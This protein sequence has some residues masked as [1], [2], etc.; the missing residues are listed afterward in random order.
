MYEYT[1]HL[2]IGS[3]KVVA[4]TASAIEDL[5]ASAFLTKLWRICGAEVR[6]TQKK[7]IIFVS[8]HIRL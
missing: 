5:A 2:C 6:K 3:H 7:P 8:Q 4:N 1:Q